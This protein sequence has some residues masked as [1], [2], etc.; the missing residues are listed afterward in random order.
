MGQDNEGQVECGIR[1]YIRDHTEQ[2]LECR[3]VTWHQQSTSQEG[4]SNELAAREPSLKLTVKQAPPP[5]S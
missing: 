2:C 5:I 1:V 4:K 3:L